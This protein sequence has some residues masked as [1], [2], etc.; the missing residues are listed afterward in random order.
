LL[1]LTI[2][3][4][5]FNYSNQLVALFVEGAAPNPGHSLTEIEGGADLATKTYVDNAVS[6][7]TGSN[8][9][10][11]GSNLYRL[12]GNVG[13]GIA[14]PTAKLDVAG[15]VN[16]S[17]GIRIGGENL[18]CEES[19]I[20]Y[21]KYDDSLYICSRH[22]SYDGDDLLLHMEG[23]AG[24]SVFLDS[25]EH[26]HQINSIGEVHLRTDKK[27]LGSASAYFDGSG[28][29]LS[30]PDSE[31]WD[32]IGDF[33]IDFYIL[34]EDI[35]SYQFPIVHRAYPVFRGAYHFYISQSKFIFSAA[36]DS[37]TTIID[38]QDTNIR[39][40]NTWYHVTINR[41]GSVAKMYVDGE[42][43]ATDN[44]ADGIISYDSG[45]LIIGYLNNYGG[46]FKGYLDEIIINNATAEDNINGPEWEI[47][48]Y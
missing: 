16:I 2:G 38:L 10:V 22:S 23:S 5:T 19:T 33:T 32:F 24:S 44:F 7:I 41:I 42:L 25:G 17:G 40:S 43:V 48:Q 27:V 29:Y 12:D 6:G 34:S 13:I 30:I 28:D 8:W 31:S 37:S 14:S 3:I 21:L 36:N 35:A 46:S 11:G 45:P 1:L 15:N 20:G 9:I 47:I 26:N 4:V 39:L 18:T